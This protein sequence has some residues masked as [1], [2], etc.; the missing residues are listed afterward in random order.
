MNEINSMPVIEISFKE[1]LFKNK[2]NRT[3]LL[4]AGAAV[5]I[6]FAI[7]KYFYPFASFIHGDSFSYLSTAYYNFDI[8]TYMVGYSRFIRLFSVFTS[9]D[10]ALVSFQYLFI[11]S[12]ALFLLFTLF[13]FYKLSRVIQIVLLC[14]MVFNPLFWHLGNLISSDCFFA[15]LSL[16]WFALLLWIINRPSV[17]III[18]HALVLFLAF[19]VRY[20]ALIYPFISAAVF[21]LSKLPVRRKMVGIG[22]GAL[23]CFLFVFYTS[24]K[25][26]QLTGYWQYSPFS[27]WQFANNAMY[28]YRYVDSAARKPVP[29]KFQVLDKMI[30]EYFDSTRDLRKYP[31]EAVLAGTYYMWSPGMPLFKYR[32]KVFKKDTSAGELKKWSSMG[33]LYKSYGTHII[34]KYPLHFAGYF[35]W[36][37]ANKYYAPPVEFLASFNSGRDSVPVLAQ[38]WF[39]YKSQKLFKRTKNPEIHILDFYPILT[40][41]INVVMVIGLLSFALLSGFAKNNHLRSAIMLGGIIWLLNAGFTIFASSAALRFQSFPILLTT[42]FTLILIDW[43]W[44]MATKKQEEANPAIQNEDLEKILSGEVTPA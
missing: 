40:G 6:Q 23:L 25:Y 38:N 5:V 33:P 30:R 37:N 7:F 11:H 13:Y 4:L 14:F 42:T 17:R 31:T 32:E 29:I 9:S 39:G 36:P 15:S 35:L 27:G 24:Y 19:T 18:W 34:G 44:S 10:T 2:R 20:N 3:I 26:K 43:I 41:V 21:W 12:S 16:V 1:F 28:T 8:N 22:A